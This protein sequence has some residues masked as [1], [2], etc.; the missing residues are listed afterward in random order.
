MIILYAVY[1]RTDIGDKEFNIR[2][3]SYQEALS[4]MLILGYPK[5]KFYI[6]PVTH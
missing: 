1:L 6:V 2:F 5:N 3:F 4:R